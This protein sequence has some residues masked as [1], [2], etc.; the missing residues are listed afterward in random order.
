MAIRCQ[1]RRIWYAALGSRSRAA[2][3]S[4]GMLEGW[5]GYLVRD[6][7]ADW[8]SVRHPARWR[9]ACCA[10]LIRYCTG[11][12]ELHPQWQAQ[13]SGDRTAISL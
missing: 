13:I 1:V 8:V 7:Y 12:L 4:L 3:E 11:V 6:D 2:I 9:P 5:H 10:Q